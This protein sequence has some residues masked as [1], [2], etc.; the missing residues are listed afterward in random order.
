MKK[1]V[2]IVLTVVLSLML[3]FTCTAKDYKDSECAELFC[4]DSSDEK[5][6]IPKSRYEQAVDNMLKMGWTMD[7]INDLPEKN[8][9]E[10]TNA[11]SFSKNTKYLCYY[12]DENNQ[13]KVVEMPK[14][15]FDY[16]TNQ[17]KSELAS[18]EN[19]VSEMSS[20]GKLELSEIWNSSS[21][22]DKYNSTN[23]LKQDQYLTWLGNNTLHNSYRWE[24]VI[25]P[26]NTKKDVF[27]LVHEPNTTMVQNSQSFVYKYD[28][29]R[30]NDTIIAGTYQVDT[31]DTYE[32]DGTSGVAYTLDLKDAEASL[33]SSGHCY[34]RYTNH[35]GYMSYQTVINNTGT[36]ATSAAGGYRH[37][38]LMWVVT[39]SIT[40]MDMDISISPSYAYVNETP[41]TFCS[42]KK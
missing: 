23:Y 8:V 32:Y 14:N 6:D 38:T 30:S 13:E 40:F 37:C 34:S 20:S 12:L 7:E 18:S 22:L 36:V 21:D 2:F 1:K 9:L 19:G 11:L 41:G 25:L 17:K 39:P 42:V 33:S 5:S 3:N 31:P 24:W 15:K 35:R 16:F 10:Y 4:L 29:T 28:L 26:Q 27:Y